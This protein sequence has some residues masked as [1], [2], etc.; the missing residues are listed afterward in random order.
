MGRSWPSKADNTVYESRVLELGL[1]NTLCI[2][3]R[4]HVQSGKILGSRQ[5]LRL[6]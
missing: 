2:Q 4:T 3:S 1:H 5:G 6:G